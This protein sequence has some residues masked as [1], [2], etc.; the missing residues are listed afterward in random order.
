ME[1]RSKYI[2]DNAL[3]DKEENPLRKKKDIHKMG[4]QDSR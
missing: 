2:T 1:D 4:I 3:W